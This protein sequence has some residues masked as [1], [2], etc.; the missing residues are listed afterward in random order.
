[1]PSAWGFDRIGT[2]DQVAAALLEG[3]EKPR[4]KGETLIVTGE[5]ASGL[6]AKLDAAGFRHH[7]VPA[8]I[9]G[10]LGAMATIAAARQ[11]D[12]E[13]DNLFALQPLYLAPSAAER[14]LQAAS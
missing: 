6:A 13:G 5:L 9:E 14:N 3:N 2:A 1:V 11:H 10:V 7:F 12:G 8:P 4:K